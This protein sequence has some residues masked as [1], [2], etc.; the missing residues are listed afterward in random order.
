M[1]LETRVAQLEFPFLQETRMSLYIAHQIQDMKSLY[2]IYEK[3]GD[4]GKPMRFGDF[5]H[6]VWVL[7]GYAKRFR[8]HN[9]EKYFYDLPL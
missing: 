2:R 9:H 3:D 6:R 4:F 7:N 5:V 1:A 8:E